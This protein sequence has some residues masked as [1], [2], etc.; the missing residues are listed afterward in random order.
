LVGPRDVKPTNAVTD[1]LTGVI[2]RTPLGISST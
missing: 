2:V 1:V